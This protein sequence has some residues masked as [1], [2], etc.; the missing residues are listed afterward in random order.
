MT[1]LDRSLFNILIVIVQSGYQLVAVRIQGD[2]NC[3]RRGGSGWQTRIIHLGSVAHL[4]KQAGG[5][6]DRGSRIGSRH[7]GRVC[8]DCKILDQIVY[9]WIVCGGCAGGHTSRRGG[10]R[11]NVYFSICRIDIELEMVQV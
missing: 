3:G 2:C 5:G 9:G 1:C 7:T 4:I 10:Q 11:L 6:S 8:R